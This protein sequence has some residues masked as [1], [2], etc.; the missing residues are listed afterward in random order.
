MP[1]D[2]TPSN[3]STAADGITPA[4][5]L[6]NKLILIADDAADNRLLLELILRRAGARTAFATDGAEAVSQT[7]NMQPDAVIMDIQM[8][9][10]DGYT[11]TRKLREL[12]FRGPII[13]CTARGLREDIW[14]SVN[15]GCN[16]HITK[17]LQ[18]TELFRLL[19]QV[20][21]EAASHH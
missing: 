5:P 9:K 7:M 14:R 10:L 20:W 19:D 6:L 13:S 3:S 4:Q 11:A 17:P 1:V 16:A 21:A 12:G 18:R 2:T 15:S 8:P